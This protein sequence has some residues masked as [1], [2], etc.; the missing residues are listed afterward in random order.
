MPMFN[1][2]PQIII[3]RTVRGLKLRNVRTT[4]RNGTSKISRKAAYNPQFMR[5]FP[6]NK[7]R[8]STRVGKEFE[9]QYERT[10]RLYFSPLYTMRRRLNASPDEDRL[11]RADYS[12]LSSM[13]NSPF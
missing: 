9:E 13:F 2:W 3:P 12:D 11:A 8:L 6:R 10:D 7:N 1:L 4:Q 5:W